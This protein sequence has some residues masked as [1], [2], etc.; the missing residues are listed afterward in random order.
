[1]LPERYIL[2]RRELRDGKWAKVPCDAQGRNIDPL[3]PAA[4]QA[5]AECAKHATWDPLMPTL[6][7]GVGFVL[8]G[9]GWW[10]L[11]MDNVRLSDGSWEPEAEALFLSFTGALG[12]V[13]TSGLGLQ[14]LGKCNPSMLGDS[15]HKWDGR[16]EWYHDKRFVALS[17]DGP[18]PIGGSWRDADWTQNLL[19]VVPQRAEMADVLPEG[20]DERCTSPEDDEELIKLALRSGGAG[21]Q[22]GAKAGFKHLWEADKAVLVHSYPAFSGEGYDQSA[23]DAALMLHLAFW[24]GRDM[25]RMDRLFRRSGLMREKYGQRADYRKSTIEGAARQCKAVYDHKG[26]CEASEP[27]PLVREPAPGKPYPVEALGPLR[28]AVEAV[29][30]ATHSRRW[31]YPLSRLWASPRLPCRGMWTLRHW[32]APGRP[33]SIC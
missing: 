11:D 18:Q 23:A 10:M 29:Q 30:G 13:S 21:V 32:T 27:Q 24:T 31:P 26:P 3:N 33:R 6:P 22:F 16:Y 17:Q 8:N 28:D 9:D 19:K 15:K 20:R 12:E 25:A 5:Y 2:Y 4:W 7:Y 14:V 1:M